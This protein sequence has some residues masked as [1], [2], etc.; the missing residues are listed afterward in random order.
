MAT[1]VKPGAFSREWNPQ[2]RW[3]NEIN[4]PRVREDRCANREEK[5]ASLGSRQP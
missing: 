5:I 2:A 3:Q 1:S 4:E